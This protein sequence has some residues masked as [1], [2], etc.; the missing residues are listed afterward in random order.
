M[1]D[2]GRG[3]LK[4]GDRGR[5]VKQ[6]QHYLAAL[7][8]DVGPLDG[9]FGLVTEEAVESFQKDF[10]LKPDGVVGPRTAEFFAAKIPNSIYSHTVKEGE[11]LQGIAKS[12]GLAP[13][14]LLSIN[15]LSDPRVTLGQKLQIPTR[16]ILGSISSGLHQQV[17]SL[18]RYR[19]RLDACLAGEL[20]FTS[21]GTLA[22][23]LLL[24]QDLREWLQKQR[25]PLW[26]EVALPVQ[27]ADLESFLMRRRVWKQSLEE[28]VRQVRLVGAQGI[29]LVLGPT[30]L[31]RHRYLLN[32]LVK[33]INKR[34]R[35]PLAI[36]IPAN[37]NLGEET[38]DFQNLRSY[39]QYFI[40]PGTENYQ[41][42]GRRLRLI[43][44]QIPC[45]QVILGL[46]SLAADR[47]LKRKIGYINRY[48]L[49]GVC[50]IGL[51]REGD[52]LWTQL[53][54]EFLSGEINQRGSS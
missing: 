4:Y 21:S 24:R 31:L 35:L 2:L 8:Y 54:E 26:L 30:L 36:A 23:E 11:T 10:H 25:L 40:I 48:N 22:G 42:V 32:R 50:I 15:K 28:L 12:Y 29:V 37:F 41:E 7:G 18:F 20:S 9:K 51:G 19:Q 46:G 3:G 53:R 43:L 49:G 1:I 13:R 47:Q 27:R 44:L 45:W 6:L 17:G 52:G 33:Q 14:V 39:C 38:L 16:I 5:E 34:I